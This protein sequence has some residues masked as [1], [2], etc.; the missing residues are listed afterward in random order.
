M[1]NSRLQ[2]RSICGWQ[3]GYDITLSTATLKP[4]PRREYFSAV[5]KSDP[6]HVYL[7]VKTVHC[8]Y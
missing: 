5:L 7:S 8:M 1:L 6:Q 4:G 3:L 2:L